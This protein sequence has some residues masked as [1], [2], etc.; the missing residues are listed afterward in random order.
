MGR[1]IKF[2]EWVKK[3]RGYE[4]CLCPGH[5]PGDMQVTIFNEELN[6]PSRILMQFTGLLDKNGKDIYEGDIVEC[7]MSFNGG[8]LPHMGEIVFMDKFGAFATKNLS[9]ETLIHHHL[10]SSFVV[11]GNIHENSEL[12]TQ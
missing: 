11:L 9:G 7:K 5:E 12:L 1:V 8:F 10:L 2:R 3:Y 4:M 6:D